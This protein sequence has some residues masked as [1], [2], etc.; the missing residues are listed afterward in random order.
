VKTNHKRSGEEKKKIMVPPYEGPK[1]LFLDIETFPNLVNVWRLYEDNALNV[2][3]FSIVACFCAK[4]LNGNQVTKALPD[5]K[6]YK[7]DQFDD[8][9][10]VNDIW[11]LLDEADIVVAHNGDMFDFKKVNARFIFH[12]LKPPAPYRTVDT[13]KVAKNIF[14]FESNRLTSLGE[15][16]GLGKKLDTGGFKLWQE[17]MLGKKS[18]WTLMKE[19]NEQDVILLE[20]I[21]LRF[22]PWIK[23]HPNM[24]VYE[25]SDPKC[26]KCG[27]FR[28]QSRG[29]AVTNSARYNRVQC[30]SCGG[31]ARFKVNQIPKHRRPIQNL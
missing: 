2:E 30:V 12:D 22:L 25:D 5:Y 29:Y 27:S 15:Y 24:A 8:H 19:Y 28:L 10:L 20:K 4:W 14:M 26:P 16:L 31:W 13:K 7:V 23:N 17:C 11:A 3:R 1:I 18:A 6:T 21:Y 9:E